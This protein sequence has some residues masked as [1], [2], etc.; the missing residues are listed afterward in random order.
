MAFPIRLFNNTV[1]KEYIQP[2]A[3][4]VIIAPV[5]LMQTSTLDINPIQ[6]EDG[7]AD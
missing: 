2:K 6:E 3:K 7:I 4:V 5:T 1:M